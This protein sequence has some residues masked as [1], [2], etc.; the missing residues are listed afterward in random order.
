MKNL[1]V[2]IR[3]VIGVN[4]NDSIELLAFEKAAISN[5]YKTEKLGYNLFLVVNDELLNKPV[6]QKAISILNGEFKFNIIN[7]AENI[8]DTEDCLIEKISSELV[9]KNKQQ[10]KSCFDWNEVFR[11]RNPRPHAIGQSNLKTQGF[12]DSFCFAALCRSHHHQQCSS[13]L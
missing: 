3:S 12:Q 4:N 8:N 13:R 5:L 2:D 10:A 9:V 11:T 6:I 1:F 7:N